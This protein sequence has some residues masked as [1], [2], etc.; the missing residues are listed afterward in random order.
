M[1]DLILHHYPTSPFAEKVRLVLGY[2]QL[3]WKSVHIPPVMPKPDVLALTGGC[4]ASHASAPVEPA[5]P[6]R[7]VRPLGGMGWPHAVRPAKRGVISA[8]RAACRSSCP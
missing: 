1:A 6:G 4:G 5:L 3:A 8:S 2:K 7:R